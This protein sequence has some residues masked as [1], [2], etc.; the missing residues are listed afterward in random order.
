MGQTT[1]TRR[2]GCDSP[3]AADGTVTNLKSEMLLRNSTHW[4]SDTI[5]FC[6]IYAINRISKR[7]NTPLFHV[8]A[9]PTISVKF[10][11]CSFSRVPIGKARGDLEPETGDNDLTIYTQN[12]ALWLTHET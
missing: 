6:Q 2:E 11:P 7:R 8:G 4:A 10:T 1:G 12:Y 5:R 9:R 3:Q